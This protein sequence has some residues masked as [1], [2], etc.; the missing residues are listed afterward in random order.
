MRDLNLLHEI[1]LPLF[2]TFNNYLNSILHSVIVV[3][4]C[5]EESSRFNPTFYGLHERRN[6]N[7]VFLKVA[8]KFF[9]DIIKGRAVESLF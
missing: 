1:V 8:C 9:I 4:L 3:T 7:S 5:N 6:S 2:T